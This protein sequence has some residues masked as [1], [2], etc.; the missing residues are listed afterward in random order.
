MNDV[1]STTAGLSYQLPT[2]DEDHSRLDC[3]QLGN[4]ASYNIESDV[5][6]DEQLLTLAAHAR[7][8]LMKWNLS[9]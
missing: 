1:H 6:L 8:G 7:R 3:P 9:F 2:N 4:Q 5:S